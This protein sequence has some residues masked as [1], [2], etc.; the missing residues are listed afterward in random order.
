MAYWNLVPMCRKH[1]SLQHQYGW[2]R[3]IEKEPV[4]RHAL[5]RRGW[6]IENG[7]LFHPELPEHLTNP[8]L[9]TLI[10]EKGE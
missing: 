8:K 10:K 3:F 9:K 4:V 6:T 7:K 1:H 2:I 5:T